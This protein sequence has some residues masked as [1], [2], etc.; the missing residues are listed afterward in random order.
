[1]LFAAFGAVV[2]I[3][4]W[5]GSATSNGV[6][7]IA[8]LA[9]AAVALWCL[10]FGRSPERYAIESTDAGIRVGSGEVV[11]W[12]GI[13]AIRGRQ[14]RQRLDLLGAN[15]ATLAGIEYQ[16]ENI[17]ELLAELWRRSRISEI[18]STAAIFGRRRPGVADVL[19]TAFLLALAGGSVW[20]WIETRHWMWL[21]LVPA[22]L[23]SAYS[24]MKKDEREVELRAGEMVVRTLLRED[25]IPA[26]LVTGA[27]LGMEPVHGQQVL[28]TIVELRNDVTVFLR[29]RGV[30][31]VALTAA[32]KRWTAGRAG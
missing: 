14:I 10:R 32:V 24:E 9:F 18:P 20:L 13:V 2:L 11:P 12:S 26:D 4:D 1:V 27:T 30:D 28:S 5:S 31:P 16:V 7:A 6:L 15:G 23:W 29:P 8:T 3:F 19:S 21:V 25:R 22:V 17:E